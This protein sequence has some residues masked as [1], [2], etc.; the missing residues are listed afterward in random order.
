MQDCCNFLKFSF[1]ISKVP[2]VLLKPYSLGVLFLD[3]LVLYCNKMLKCLMLLS[4]GLWIALKKDHCCNFH[5]NNIFF[6][7]S[8]DLEQFI[9]QICLRNVRIKTLQMNKAFFNFTHK[10]L[11]EEFW[12][13]IWLFSFIVF[14]WFKEIECI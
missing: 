10:V 2:C 1:V 8:K 12:R 14:A 4:L 6:L 5:S 7:K 3:F 9:L 13:W 11:F